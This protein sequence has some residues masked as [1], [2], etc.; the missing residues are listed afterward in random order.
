VTKAKTGKTAYDPLVEK[1]KADV[2][3]A[4]PVKTK[5]TCRKKGC[6]KKINSI[7]LKNNDPFCS[8]ICAREHYGNPLPTAS[9]WSSSHSPRGKSKDPEVSH[10]LDGG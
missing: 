8:N 9:I 10:P 6:R 1:R 7:A 5:F 4:R 2:P 3:Q